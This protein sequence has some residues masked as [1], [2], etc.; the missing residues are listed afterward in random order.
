MLRQ[1]R[2]SDWEIKNN[3]LL[4]SQTEKLKQNQEVKT[5]KAEQQALLP[6]AFPF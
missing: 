2:W 1:D 6:L 3:K 5:E 4:K